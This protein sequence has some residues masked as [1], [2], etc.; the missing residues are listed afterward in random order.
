MTM[1]IVAIISGAFSVLAA[2]VEVSRRQNK[3][4]HERGNGLLESI[5]ARTVRIDDKVARL[6]EWRA[7]HEQHH[8]DTEETYE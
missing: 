6:A 3:I 1:L 2:W 5:D 7:A 8:R 4:D